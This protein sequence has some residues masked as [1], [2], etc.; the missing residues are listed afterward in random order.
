MPHLWERG[1]NVR[2]GPKAPPPR[3]YKPKS[4]RAGIQYQGWDLNFSPLS[5]VGKLKPLGRTTGQNKHMGF[6]NTWRM[7]GGRC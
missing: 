7:A 2:K 6:E 5:K 3:S 4:G 1:K